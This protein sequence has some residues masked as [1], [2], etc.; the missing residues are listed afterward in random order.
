MEEYKLETPVSF[1][2]FNRPQVTERVFNVIR[3]VKPRYLFVTAD[4]PRENVPQ[5]AEKCRAVRELVEK[6]IDWQCELYKNYSD[7]NKGSYKSTSG[8]ITWV[9]QNVEEAIILE[10][11][12]LPSLSFF[13]FC[14]ELLDYYRSDTRIAIISGDNFL[15]EMRDYK[16]SYYFSRYTHMWGWATWKRTWDLVD[17]DMKGWS[18]FRNNGGLRNIFTKDNEIHY[19]DNLFQ[20]MHTKKRGPHWDYKLNLASFMNNTLT[21]MPAVN[22][23][24]NIGA[25]ID[26]TNC[27]IVGRFHNLPANEI[28]FPL[29][30]PLHVFRLNRADEYSEDNIFSGLLMQNPGNIKTVKKATQISMKAE[31][32]QKISLSPDNVIN[33]AVDSLN[34]NNNTE[35]LILL[36][37]AIG[38]KPDIPTLN[39]GKAVALS[40]LGQMDEATD[41]LKSLLSVEPNHEKAQALLNEI[42]VA[43]V[44]NLMAQAANALNA[45]KNDEAFALLNKAK[46][47]RKPAQGLDYLRAVY[48]LRINQ[49]IAA[50]ESLQEEL[51]YFPNNQEAKNVLDQILARYPQLTSSK[52]GDSEFQELFKIIRPYTMLSEERLFSLF[53]LAK[54]VCLEDIPGNF[55]ECGVAAGG[56]SALLSAVIKRYSKRPR[57]HYAF[58]SFEGMPTP[59][60]QDKQ[61]DGKAAE[62]TGWGTGTCAASEQ[63]VMEICT[64]LGVSNIIEPVKGYF[65][66]TLPEMKNEVGMIA[67]LHMDGDWYESTKTVLQNLYDHIS[68]NGIIQVDDYGHWAGCK[69]A[70]H[71]FE[72]L[73]KIKFE[74]HQIDFS[75]VWFFKPANMSASTGL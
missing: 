63:S 24:S 53:S 31:Q 46:S 17:L 47:L 40:R 42:T 29:N 4:G 44:S 26:A 49:P 35:A 28:G 1:H 15:P 34:S 71:E 75:G 56:S 54:R 70:L 52:I 72:S 43:F 20:S 11:D 25:G 21:V 32:P 37:Q 14:R 9:F 67:L 74:I 68:A 6:N 60:E 33:K 61:Y 57:R 51:R 69:K 50:K 36:D 16:Y 12:C 64:K 30:H 41:T 48:F 39:Y 18:E 13:K 19:W 3:T 58:D 38:L 73:R 55:V 2:I 66:Q 22:L 7:V 8:G 27:K 23:V 59:T 62:A 5:D 65:E 45:N 10:D